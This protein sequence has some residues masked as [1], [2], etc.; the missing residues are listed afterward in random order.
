VNRATR[1]VVV[2]TA[3]AG[4][5][6]TLAAFALTSDRGWGNPLLILALT[7]PLAIDWAFP[8]RFLRNEEADSLQLHEVYAV[9]AMLLL[10][11]MGVLAVFLIGT[12]CGLLLRRLTWIKAVFNLGQTMLSVVV[13]LTIFVLIDNGAPGEIS[14]RA[15]LAAIVAALAMSAISQALV[16]LVI[17]TSEG[18]PFLAN[19][20]DGLGLRFLQWVSAVSVGMLA[21]LSAATYPWSLA[22]AALPLVLIHVVLSEH[23]RARLDRERLRRLLRTAEEVHSSVDT[24][25][26][27]S[28]LAHSAKELLRARD[29]WVGTTSPAPDERGV[30]LPLSD[31]QEQWLVVSG[32]KGVS[33]FDA[34]DVQLLEAIGT[35]GASALENAHLVSQIRHQATHDRLTG[36]P[37]QLLFED[38]VNQAVQRARRLREKLAVLMV[39]LDGFQK[40]NASLGH[41]V[42]NELL[43]RVGGRLTSAVREGDTVARMSADD[44]TILLPGLGDGEGLVAMAEQLLGAVSRPFVVDGHELFMTSSVGIAVFPDDGSHAGQLLR[45]ADTAMHRAK[46]AGG[47]CSRLYDPG[48]NEQAQVHLARRSELHNAL[49]R[50]ELRVLYQPQIDLRTGRVVGVEALVRWEHPTLGLLTP[51][52]FVPLA[53]ESD[54]VVEVDTWVMRHACRQAVEWDAAGLPPLRMAANLS[55]RN[56]SDDRIV[57]RV[58]MVLQETGLA[59]DR[60][61]LEITES[62]ALRESEG[63]LEIVRRVRDLGPRFAIDDFGTGY[64]ALAQMQRFPVDRLKIDRTFVNQITS[65]QGVAPL[66]SAFIGIA[67]A[68]RLEVVAEGVETLEQ[69]SFLRMHGCK[70]AQGFLY[71][72]PIP[73]EQIVD[74]VRKP[75][76][77]LHVGGS[78]ADA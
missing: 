65:A 77:G 45:N 48:T 59:A 74:M 3:L 19:L 6:A 31:D 62:L 35:I 13:G 9:I 53:E 73:P 60:L 54:L 58:A 55:G 47:N 30:R 4:L 72:R 52:D 64:S 7:A 2:G 70:E 75:S 23:L 18:I 27:T 26:V 14:V 49:R 50:D 10:P 1:F 71:S 15:V 57:G 51:A 17:A 33:G 22:L 16:S 39:D 63:A 11:P 40:V 56:F 68:L 5:A 21:A 25:A 12:V 67:R 76:L 36:L 69:Q 8:L 66:V 34:D 61:E 28:S 20:R 24:D 38:R 43:K 41:A 42:G 37:N 32:R 44:F 46:D 29:A 78:G